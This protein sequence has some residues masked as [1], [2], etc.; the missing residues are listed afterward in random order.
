MSLLQYHDPDLIID[1]FY[2][3]KYKEYVLNIECLLCQ[4]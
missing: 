4:A 3:S 1:T 2:A